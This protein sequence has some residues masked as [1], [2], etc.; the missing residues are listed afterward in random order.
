MIKSVSK[1][2]DVDP[3]EE[4]DIIYAC[5]HMKREVRYG[6]RPAVGDFERCNVPN[7]PEREQVPA[8]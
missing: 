7:C 2:Q 4:W 6:G 3:G 5:G 1:V 8:A